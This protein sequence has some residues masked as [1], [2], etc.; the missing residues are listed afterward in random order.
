MPNKL[1]VSRK[2]S[3]SN[4]NTNSINN[5]NMNMLQPIEEINEK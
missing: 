5:T 3:G 1:N 4:I 2:S